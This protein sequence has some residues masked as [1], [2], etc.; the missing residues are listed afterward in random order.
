MFDMKSETLSI[1]RSPCRITG[2]I[3]SIRL[4]KNTWR[5]ERDFTNKTLLENGYL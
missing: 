4:H 3:P 5:K 1:L 2:Y